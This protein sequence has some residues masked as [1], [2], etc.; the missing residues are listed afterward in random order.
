M[1]KYITVLKNTI[2][3]EFE[4]RANILISFLYELIGLF[5][6]VLFWTTVYSTNENI[7]GVEYSELL[8]YFLLVPIVGFIANTSISYKIG[9]EIKTGTLSADLLK[10]Y[11]IF[12]R[13]F[14]QAVANRVNKLVIV[15]PVYVFVF[16]ILSIYLNLQINLS[17]LPGLVLFGILGFILSVIIDIFLGWL[18][19]WVDDIWAFEHLKSILVSIFGG[20]LFP[21]VF[22]SESMRSVFELLPF[23]F[24]YSVP[25]RAISGEYPL[26]EFL[27][28][29]IFIFIFWI[30]FFLILINFIWREGISKFE[31]YG[32]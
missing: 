9:N 27:Q 19:F 25:L 16:A 24:I 12:G 22:L 18:A 8:T 23:K 10:P 6:I 1:K 2:S 3:A 29:D 21:F 28:R 20:K 15:L 14:S 4:F 31:A 11:S 32:N 5:V 30:L 13:I 7:G 17:Y 26:S